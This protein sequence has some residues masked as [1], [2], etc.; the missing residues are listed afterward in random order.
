MGR[1]GAIAG[2]AGAAGAASWWPALPMTAKVLRARAERRKEGERAVSKH[3]GGADTAGERRRHSAGADL[4]LSLVS[5]A[6]PLPTLLAPHF[7]ARA[8]TH[9]HTPHRTRA[10]QRGA[11]GGAGRKGGGG[12]RASYL[13]SVSLSQPSFCRLFGRQGGF[14]RVTVLWYAEFDTSW[15]VVVPSKWGAT[16]RKFLARDCSERV[17]DRV[18]E[19]NTGRTNHEGIPILM[20]HLRY[21]HS[22]LH[23]SVV[24]GRPHPP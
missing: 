21:R 12:K 15:P 9:L 14:S 7:R 19:S 20:P 10:E 23:T 8:R 13:C 11:G 24:R 5:L 6:L 17:H 18:I 16:T 22:F 2:A 3:A 1:L 4:S